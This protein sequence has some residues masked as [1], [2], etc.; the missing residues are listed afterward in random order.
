[1]DSRTLDSHV[2]DSHQ[3]EASL[4]ANAPG[5]TGTTSESANVR[6]IKEAFRAMAEGGIGASVDALLQISHKDCRFRPASAEGRV[7]EGHDEVRAFFS[8]AET[9]GKSITVRA[10]TFE[11]HGDEVV[12]SGSMRVIQ[13]EGSFAERQ[14]R[15]IYR[16]RDGLVEEA[17][18]SPRHSD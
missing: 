7:L 14:I 9:T 13:P 10:R 17:C 6:A 4:P 11:E 5:T 16:F 1:M 2:L 3:L 15:W 12:V 18:W 8:S